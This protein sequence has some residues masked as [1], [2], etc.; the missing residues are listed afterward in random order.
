VPAAPSPLTEA[1]GVAPGLGLAGLGAAAADGLDAERAWMVAVV[2][3]EATATRP[4]AIRAARRRLRRTG[5]GP[6]S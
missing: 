5:A 4:A 2:P 3:T 6:A 1:I